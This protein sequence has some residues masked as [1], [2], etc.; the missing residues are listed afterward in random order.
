MNDD[1]N[2]E[3]DEIETIDTTAEEDINTEE[4][5][6]IDPIEAMI[7]AIEDKDFISSSN[8][9]NDLVSS[10]MTDA[11]DN[12]RIEIADR[13]YNNAPEEIDTEVD[14]EIDNEVEEDEVV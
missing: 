9:F 11:I 7:S 2:T 4:E 6:E 12:K 8:I 3:D 5:S 14:M 1:L 13:I 10:K